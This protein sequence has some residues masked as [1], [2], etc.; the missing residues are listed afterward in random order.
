MTAGVFS[1]LDGSHT[2]PKFSILPHHHWSLLVEVGIDRQAKN[3]CNPYK[4]FR[5]FSMCQYVCQLIQEIIL[6]LI[7]YKGT[8]NLFGDDSGLFHSTKYRSSSKSK[9]GNFL[10]LVSNNSLTDTLMLVKS[11]I[12]NSRLFLV[13]MAYKSKK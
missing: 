11:S 5:A 2:V 12:Q 9:F 3:M 13:L 6:I 8:S 7:T 1:Y 10:S 4:R